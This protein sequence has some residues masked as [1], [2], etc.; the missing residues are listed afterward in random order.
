VRLLIEP[1][2]CTLIIEKYYNEIFS[3]C[4]AKLGYSHHSAE[5]CTQEVFVVF[6]SK[7]ERLDETDNIRLWLYR[8]ADNVIK[9]FVRKAP[10]PAVS[11]EDSPEAMNIADSGGFTEN[12]D[13]PLD[14]LSSE[15]RQL[16]ELY[17]NSD[18]GQRN[19]AAK[20]LGLSLPAL[21]RKIHKLKKKLRAAEK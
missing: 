16:L 21:Y 1:E 19:E 9:A 17:Y 3:Y 10:P 18:Y 11:L 7:H 15:E 12:G 4:Y 2:H 14:L 6:F 13:S 8:A 20:R 5:D